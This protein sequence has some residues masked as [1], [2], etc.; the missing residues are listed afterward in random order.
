MI[1]TMNR[2]RRIN[3][4]MSNLPGP[5]QPLYFAGA[6]ILE[7]FQIGVVQGNVAVQ[8]GAL[9]YA[10]QLNL[11]VVGDA[12]LVPDLQVFAD[13]MTEDLQRLGRRVRG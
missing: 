11:D 10:G 1:H 8:V 5:Q 7:L 13:G 9:S 2:Q 12:H 6:K 3:L 4:L